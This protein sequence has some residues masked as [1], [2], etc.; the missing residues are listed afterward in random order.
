MGPLEG[1]RVVEIAGIGPGPFCA[2]VLSDLGAEVIRVDRKS[3]AGSGG[4]GNVLN[5]GRRS[6]AVDLKKPEG[7]EAVLKLVDKADA[8]IE[9]FVPGSWS[10]W[11]SARRSARGA[12][13][14]S[15]SV[16]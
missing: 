15:S 7:V 8:L 10:V 12:I 5:R 6:I 4:K 9:A 1:Y 3:A 16:A 14:A 13:P 2:M 11:A